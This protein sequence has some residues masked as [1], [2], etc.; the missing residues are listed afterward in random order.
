MAQVIPD[1]IDFEQYLR[2]DE[3]G[4]A[5]VRPASEFVDEVVQLIHGEE[6]ETGN[7][8]P[9]PKVGNLLKFRPGEVSLWAGINGHGKSGALGMVALNFLAEGAPTC[10]A[11]MEMTPRKT[12]ERMAKQA[13]ASEKPTIEYL[14]RFGQWTDGR[15]WIYAH[16][17]QVKSDRMLAVARYC[18]KELGIEHV[19][20]DSLLK[21][22]IAPDDYAGQKNFVDAL[23]ALARDTGLHIHLVH[24][25]RKGESEMSA[26][27]KFDIKGAG[28]ISDLVDNVLLIHRN[29]RKEAEMVKALAGNNLDAQEKLRMQGDTI[30]ICAKQR[31]FSWEGQVNLFFDKPSQ[32]LREGPSS[33]PRYID[34]DNGGWQQKWGR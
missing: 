12:L 19:V 17:G 8:T 14:E 21:C 33:T 16:M 30:L 32:Q 4:R 23:C 6:D 5:K 18:R 29:K 20:I 10:I 11:S 31:H 1:D 15:L 34:F 13:A 7:S 9:W 27:D 22:G 24:H 3:D 26:P 28:E 2:D 25:I